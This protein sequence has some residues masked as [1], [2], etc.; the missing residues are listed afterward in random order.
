MQCEYRQHDRKRAPASSDYAQSLERRVRSLEARIAELEGLDG[1]AANYAPQPVVQ[2]LTSQTY[3]TSNSGRECLTL[4]PRGSLVYH[5]TTSILR[6]MGSPNDFLQVTGTTVPDYE[7]VASHFGIDLEGTAIMTGLQHFFK[8]QYPNFM[9]IYRE[10]FLED[11]F[12][13][14]AA[15][16]YWSPALLLSVCALGLLMSDGEKDKAE[17]LKCFNAAESIALVTGFADPSVVAVQTF[18]CLAFYSIGNGNLSKGWAF[19]GEYSSSI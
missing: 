2:N 10:A 8:W 4:D 11:H 7:H 9:F 12:G 17:S 13:T 6:D 3:L 14:R 15:S 1:H 5:G 16:R 19:S 18:L